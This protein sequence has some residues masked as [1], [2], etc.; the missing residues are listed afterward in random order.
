MKCRLRLQI[1]TFHHLHQKPRKFERYN[2]SMADDTQQQIEKRLAEL[3]EDVR[4]AILSSDLDQKL[5]DIAQK[6][7]LHVDQGS[8]LSDETML[9]M[10]G[11]SDPSEFAGNLAAQLHMPP[12][13]AQALAGE[14]S[15]QVFLPIRDSM[16]KFMEARAQAK[17]AGAPLQAAVQKPSDAPTPAGQTFAP[18][19]VV[20]PSPIAKPQ[21]PAMPAAER[22]LT[23]KTVTP[24]P[25]SPPQAP[26]PAAPKAPA[27]PV[28]NSYK[29][30]PYREPPE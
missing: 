7:S 29:V 28:P 2:K 14:V 26:P 3:P 11:F 25:A 16:K 18:P 23:E 12:A 1:K 6:H 19:P 4:Q 24:P 21:P 9:V 22:M 13:D 27:P 17:P 5:R 20:A 30:D 15:E 8:A 10:L